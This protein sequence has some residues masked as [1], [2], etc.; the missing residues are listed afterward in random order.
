MSDPIKAAVLYCPFCNAK[1]MRVLSVAEDY[2]SVLANCPTCRR[3][4]RLAFPPIHI[5]HDD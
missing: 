4:S 2:R 5:P 1:G 3:D